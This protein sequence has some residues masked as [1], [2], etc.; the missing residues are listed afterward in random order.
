MLLDIGGAT[1]DLHYTTDII[2]ED[3]EEKALPGPNR[4]TERRR[5]FR[6]AKDPMCR[7]PQETD[8]VEEML[9]RRGR[10]QSRCWASHASTSSG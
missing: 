7:F 8:V 6:C 4:S 5:A 2:R 3:S 9:D 1:T 10:A